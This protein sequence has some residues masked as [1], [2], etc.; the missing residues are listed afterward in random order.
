MIKLISSFISFY[1]SLAQ[2]AG[3]HADG[4]GEE[5]SAGALAARRLGKG[6]A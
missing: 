6:M 5:R 4:E 2:S 1:P 3:G